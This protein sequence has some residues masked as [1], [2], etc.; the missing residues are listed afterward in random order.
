[1]RDSVRLAFG[2]AVSIAAHGLLLLP[3][4]S[5]GGDQAGVSA[6][7]PSLEVVAV[8]P[9]R[10]KEILEPSV[11]PPAPCLAG[12]NTPPAPRALP[13]WPTWSLEK[14]VESTEPESTRLLVLPSI[15]AHRIAASA[16]PELLRP[17]IDL[18]VVDVVPLPPPTAS[19]ATGPPRLEDLTGLVVHQEPLDY[20]LQAVR[21]HI[22]GTVSVAVQ[23]DGEGRVEDA[24]VLRSS[25]SRLLDR[26]ARENLLRWRFDPAAVEAA[27]L[28]HVFR[29][30]VLFEID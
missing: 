5:A 2:A 7:S 16:A 9:E 12:A 28:G 23:V 10:V 25:G 15:D 24:R 22:E 8:D 19:G 6:A 11:R 17:V 3:G 26:T 30:D 21:R 13:E 1:M 14:P 29:Q 18:P 27:G 20:P 4:F